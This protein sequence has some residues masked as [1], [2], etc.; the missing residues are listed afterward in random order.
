[1]KKLPNKP[2]KLLKRALKDLEAVEV[3]DNYVIDMAIYHQ[4]PRGSDE[5]HVCLAGSAMAKSLKAEPNAERVPN[6][7]DD[8]VKGKLIALDCFRAGIIDNA[9]MFMS[10]PIPHTLPRRVDVTPYKKSPKR[11]KKDM[12]KIIKLLKKAGL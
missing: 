9:L 4:T 6:N 7:Y 11:F 8:K 12:K 10:R 2:S 1:M 5:C 3:D